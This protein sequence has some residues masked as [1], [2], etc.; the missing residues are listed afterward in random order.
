M[1]ERGLQFFGIKAIFVA[2]IEA[3]I[4]TKLKKMECSFT[5]LPIYCI[6][7]E[8]VKISRVSV[9]SKCLLRRH[10]FYGFMDFL[11]YEFGQQ[12]SSHASFHLLLNSRGV[13]LD[14]VNPSSFKKAPEI[15]HKGLLN[16][17]LCFTLPSASILNS[18]VVTQIIN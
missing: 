6:P 9:E 10:T 8:L 7:M 12:P 1:T 15:G 18:P 11:P 17:C 2:F 3:S 4:L 13:M 14:L 5:N 16:F